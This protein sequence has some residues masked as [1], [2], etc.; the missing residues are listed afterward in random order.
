MKC[1]IL[2]FSQ[3][4]L[5][6]YGLTMDDALILRYFIDF[7]DTG[8]M[9]KEEIEGKYYYW[10]KYEN[11]KESLPIL[12]ISKDRIYRKLKNLATLGILDHKTIRKGGTFSFYSIGTEYIKLIEDDY[13]IKDEKKEEVSPEKN[14]GEKPQESC[15]DQS[16]K[17]PE[18]TVKT[19][20]PYGKNNVTPTVKIPYPYGKNNGTKDISL[21]DKSLK[22]NISLK[23]IFINIVQYLNEKAGTKYKANS[24][25]TQQLISARVKE[26][27]TLEDFKIVIDKKVAEWINTELEKYLRPETLF[28]TKFEG[29]LNQKSKT[30]FNTKTKPNFCNYEQRKYDGAD[31][32]RT[33]ADIEKKLLGW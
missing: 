14:Q 10:I 21:K 13:S 7:K 20:H 23:D 9:V 3:R 18:G 8:K 17:I 19:P 15:K 4:K 27:F 5:V 6:E 33:L 12:D 16:V 30:S 24:K 28:G 1:S 11:L 2:G 22:E 31:G 26:G 25:K 29:Y 32:S